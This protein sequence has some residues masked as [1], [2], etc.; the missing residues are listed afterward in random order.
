L[1]K[2]TLT[3]SL[4]TVCGSPFGSVNQIA[5]A[6]RM[7]KHTLPRFLDG[8]D[9]VVVGR[10]KRYLLS[11]VAEAICSKKNISESRR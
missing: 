11:D 4:E 10:S 9:C 7:S 2:K 6:L 5:S 3:K 1:D 8:L